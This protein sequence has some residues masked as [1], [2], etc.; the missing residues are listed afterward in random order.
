MSTQ[1]VSLHAPIYLASNS[2]HLGEEEETQEILCQR[3][4]NEK[5]D[6]TPDQDRS[7]I[8]PSEQHLSNIP[9][10]PGA[11]HASAVQPGSE[12]EKKKEKKEEETGEKGIQEKKK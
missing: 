3:R 7:I 4:I 1:L 10:Q 11:V 12:R 6:N 5:A 9:S 8:T 2:F